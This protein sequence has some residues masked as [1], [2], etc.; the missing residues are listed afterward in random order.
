MLNKKMQHD[1]FLSITFAQMST[2]KKIK[3]LQELGEFELGL[4]H[5]NLEKKKKLI[6]YCL[7]H[8]SSKF[9]IKSKYFSPKSL[10]YMEITMVK[11]CFLS[12]FFYL[13][14]ILDVKRIYF[15]SI[16]VN[17]MKQS[18]WLHFSLTTSLCQDNMHV[19]CT[20]STFH[21]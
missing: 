10:Y 4:T 2:S 17:Y 6:A 8:G 19:E 5:S 18:G 20:F 21:Y 15:S 3:S 7:G 16:L 12:H 14:F 11:V 13:S 9:I 1:F